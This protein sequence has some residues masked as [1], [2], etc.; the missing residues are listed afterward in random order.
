MIE[1]LQAAA[2]VIKGQRSIALAGISAEA[3]E[4]YG[5]Q[6]VAYYINYPG[7]DGDKKY[8]GAMRN[9]QK[10]INAAGATNMEHVR[11]RKLKTNFSEKFIALLIQ[12]IHQRTPNGCFVQISRY[13]YNSCAM[14]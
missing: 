3:S 14:I 11:L 9:I 6:K 7:G 10:H 12:Q 4:R 8:L 1:D 13:K 5:K 2:E